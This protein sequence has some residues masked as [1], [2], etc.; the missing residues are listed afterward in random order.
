MV[1]AD[2]YSQWVIAADTKPVYGTCALTCSATLYH[3]FVMQL[4]KTTG[5]VP[6][7]GNDFCPISGPF[8]F[9]YAIMQE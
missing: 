4:I 7:L 8:S 9:E 5:N 3:Q 6:G 2:A 1:A